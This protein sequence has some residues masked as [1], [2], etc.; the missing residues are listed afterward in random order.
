M[1][2]KKYHVRKFLNKSNG[3]AA[4]EIHSNYTAWNFDCGITLTDCNRRIDLDFSMWNHKEA[5]DKLDK[6]N[7]LITE[8]TKL[9]EFLEPA[10]ADFVELNKKTK[11]NTGGKGT[12]LVEELADD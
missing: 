10:I 4:L 11:I 5:K 12:S 3:I 1:S 9:K 6:L 7:L 2:K 8:F